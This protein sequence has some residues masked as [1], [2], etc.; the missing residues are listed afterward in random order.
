M[1]MV[2]SSKSVTSLGRK[3]RRYDLTNLLTCYDNDPC[4]SNRC[5]VCNPTYRS[6]L[7]E[8]FEEAQQR[9]K[10][11][12]VNKEIKRAKKTAKDEILQGKQACIVSFLTKTSGKKIR[13]EK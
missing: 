12:K 7:K 8:S 11:E 2:E 9:R 13:L 1:K 6:P 10:M 5:A 3:R 4:R